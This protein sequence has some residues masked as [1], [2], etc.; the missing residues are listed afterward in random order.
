[1]KKV[2]SIL[3]KIEYGFIGL[4]LGGMVAVVFLATFARYSQLFS[5]PWAEEMARYFM[6]WLCFVG[7]GAVARTGTHFSVDAVE[8]K[9]SPAGK[10]VFY[11][12][13]III[14]SGI[15]AWIAWYG[16]KICGNQIKMSRT[17]P[18]M[19]LPMWLVSSCVPYTAISCGVQNF[20]HILEKFKTLKT[21]GKQEEGGN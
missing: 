18:S 16:L 13:Q 5:T 4:C 20:I 12:L 15:C 11:W 1:M 14:I 9:L 2:C 21:A 10:K 19:N 6:I 7:S 17:S 3:Q 8:K